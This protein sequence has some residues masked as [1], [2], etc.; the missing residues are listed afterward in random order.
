MPYTLCIHAL[1]GHWCIPKPNGT[2]TVNIE[3]SGDFE[4]TSDSASRAMGD[5]LTA[6]PVILASGFG[7]L[8]VAFIYTWFLEKCAGCMVFIALC[9]TVCVGAVLTSAFWDKYNEYKTTEYNNR[10]DAMQAMAIVTGVSTVLFILAVI[11]MRDRIRIAIAV[12]KD[13]ALALE[14]MR[15]LICFPIGPIFMGMAFIVWWISVALWIF[16][17]GTDV[18]VC[19][20][21]SIEYSDGMA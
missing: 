20:Q 9:A 14:D 5:M 12:V 8:V 16:S 15:I 13:A 4:N 10:A 6:W 1:V 3:L 17:V 21:L 11:V 18:P 7:C 2:V 19:L